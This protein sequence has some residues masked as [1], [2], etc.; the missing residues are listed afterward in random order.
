MESKTVAVMIDD[1]DS[2]SSF[3]LGLA[4]SLLT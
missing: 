1:K 3:V 2:V 4:L